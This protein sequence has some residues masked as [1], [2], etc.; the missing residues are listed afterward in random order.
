[1]TTRPVSIV[2]KET[3]AGPLVTYNYQI[4]SET[5]I[6]PDDWH[7]RRWSGRIFDLSILDA[8]MASF[9]ERGDIKE[10]E[11]IERIDWKYGKE[12]AVYVTILW[13]TDA[14]IKP[15]STPLGAGIGDISKSDGV[16]FDN[17]TRFWSQAEAEALAKLLG[18]L[19]ESSRKS[20]LKESKYSQLSLLEVAA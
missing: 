11:C 3:D 12:M 20:F 16:M 14:L 8:I 2:F 13:Q 4:I 15:I 17:S 18:V 5:S 1:M 6:S 7:P 19:G 9:A 10:P